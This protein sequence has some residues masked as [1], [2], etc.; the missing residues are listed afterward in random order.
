LQRATFCLGGFE[1]TNTTQ[2]EALA[3]LAAKCIAFLKD[4]HTQTR[5]GRKRLFA[6]N[7]GLLATSFHSYST[8]SRS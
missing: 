1:L 7:Q 3:G 2:E 4:K 8:H 5:E 6:L